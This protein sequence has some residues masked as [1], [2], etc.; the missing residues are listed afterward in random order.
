MD[1]YLFLLILGPTNDLGYMRRKVMKVIHLLTGGEIGGIEVL[2]KDIGIL[3]PYENMFCFVTCEGPIY[4]Q[5]KELGLSVCSLTGGHKFSIRKLKKLT[6]LV[7]DYDVIAVHHG[8]PYLNLYYCLLSKIRRDKKYVRIVHSCYEG[9]PQNYTQIKFFMS[10]MLLKKAIGCSDA[11]IFVS[12]AGLK[13][14]L[15]AFSN[16]ST[17]CTY[18]VY[19][20]IGME[21]LERGRKNISQR[22][23]SIR[24]LFVGRLH[25]NKGIPLLLAAAAILKEKYNIKLTIVGDGPEWDSL[26]KQAEKLDIID[27]VSFAGQQIDIIP[28]LENAD[29]FVYPSVWEEVFGISIVEAMAFGLIPIA[30]RVGGIPEIIRDGVN[31]FLTGEKSANGVKRAIE[32]AIAILGTEKEAEMRTLSKN[33]AEKFSIQN[34][35]DNLT[36]V[37]ERTLNDNDENRKVR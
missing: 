27:V 29:I 18:V 37:L 22:C 15:K 35:V 12:K 14:H 26:H 8:D 3:A 9:K 23:E 24:I 5:M 25:K 17:K 19:N 36:N 4:N 20:G 6:T 34:T 31:G 33:T 28:Y 21:K 7:K 11:C 13:S 10:K 30:N 2:C 1:I 16:L 32:N